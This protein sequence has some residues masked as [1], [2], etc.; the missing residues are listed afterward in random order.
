[1]RTGHLNTL[2][3]HKLI[4]ILEKSGNKDLQNL[5]QLLLRFIKIISNAIINLNLGL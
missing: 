3:K 5:E 2:I 1:M 4:Q